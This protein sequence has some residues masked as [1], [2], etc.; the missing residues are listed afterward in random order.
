M[1]LPGGI[2]III[3]AKGLANTPTEDASWA[4]ALGIPTLQKMQAGPI[5]FCISGPAESRE[6]EFWRLRASR[7]EANCCYLTAKIQFLLRE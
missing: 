5:A 1:D 6:L 7:H 4:F 2:S 3:G